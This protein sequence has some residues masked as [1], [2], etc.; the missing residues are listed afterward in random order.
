MQ[1]N[2]VEFSCTEVMHVPTHR[3][4]RRHTNPLPFF[5]W[6]TAILLGASICVFLELKTGW[7]ARTDT[8]SSAIAL[9]SSTTES[10]GTSYARPPRRIISRSLSD[11]SV[12]PYSVVPGGVR[13]SEALRAAVL[14]DPV[15]AAHYSD[16]KLA[17][18]RL[19]KLAAPESV[20]VSYRL[21]NKI[22]WTQRK[23]TLVRGEILV[24]DGEH[25]A[26]ARCG[27][28][29]S[30]VP[31]D[32]ISPYEPP[33]EILNVPENPPVRTP[34]TTPAV[35]LPLVDPRDLPTP[36]P[37]EIPLRPELPVMVTPP[38]Y[39]PTP[40]RNPP[41]V[42]VVPILPPLIGTLPIPPTPPYVPPAQVPEPGTFLLVSSGLGAL[43]LL[44]HKFL[45]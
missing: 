14:G 44:R 4:S 29:I 45:R 42:V 35:S 26:R 36:T 11:Q 6:A 37:P 9:L 39:P 23:L 19:M 40:G 16:F 3:H 12:F 18:Y 22:Y 34:D 21:G 24:T 17:N 5:L 2:A 20:Y 43:F 38:V 30:E 13:D 33:E 8:A 32:D 31:V 28:R 25:F 27:N 15:V 10:D 1:W 7:S 41:P